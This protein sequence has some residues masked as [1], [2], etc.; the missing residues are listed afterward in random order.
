MLEKNMWAVVG[1]TQNKQ[2]YGYKLYVHLK[3]KGYRVY[4]VNPAYDA[5]DGD[6]CYESLSSLPETPQV[7]SMVV[8]PKIGMDILK[9]AAGLGIKYAWFQPGSYDDEL[10]ALAKDLEIESVQ[11][12]VLIAAP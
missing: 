6:K 1:A 10:I 4:A 7:I 11:A 12:C 2:K 8:A 5:I 3:N 9:Q